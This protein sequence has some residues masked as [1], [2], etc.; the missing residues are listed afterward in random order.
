MNVLKESLAVL[1]FV[2]THPEATPAPVILVLSY[3]LTIV[4]AM[5]NFYGTDAFSFLS[6]FTH[7]IKILMSAK[8]ILMV[9]VK[10]V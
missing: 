8:K 1:R 3:W 10:F 2:P 9:V 7:Y 6:R 5:V 4:D